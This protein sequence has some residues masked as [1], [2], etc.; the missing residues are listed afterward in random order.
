MSRIKAMKEKKATLLTQMQFF[1]LDPQFRIFEEICNTHSLSNG[2]KFFDL[3]K[4]AVLATYG[5]IWLENEYLDPMKNKYN[6]QKSNLFEFRQSYID[7]KQKL[8]NKIS[9]TPKLSDI[10]IL[11]YA[12]FASGDANI[13]LHVFKAGGNDQIKM[14]VREA[15][16]DSYIQF[17]D[18]YRKK[19]SNIQNMPNYISGH[20]IG[21][22]MLNKTIKSFKTIEAI[23]AA[24]QAI[25]DANLK[26]PLSDA[27]LQRIDLV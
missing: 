21:A 17:M 26:T 18:E 8:L 15:I 3:W 27:E 24:Q 12:Y 25:P 10:D 23:I 22:E 19:I 7:T 11:C 1:C 6:V 5:Q 4:M 20:E 2:G 9:K 16:I 14:D 13:I